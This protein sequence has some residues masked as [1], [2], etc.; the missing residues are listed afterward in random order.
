MS[1]EIK[2]FYDLEAWEKAHQLVIEI[3]KATKDFPKQ[4]QFGL[5][6]QLRRAVTS[7]TANIAEGFERY[8]FNDK[9]RFY[10]QARGSV[11]EVQNFLIL[12]K[13]LGFITNAKC[14]KLEERVNELR[15]LINGLIKS[16][17]KQKI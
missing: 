5:I 14:V 15:R 8:H 6:S 7:I 10:Y 1:G 9:V 2:S 11:G 4:E 3:Y 12:A 13:D 17:E 16:I